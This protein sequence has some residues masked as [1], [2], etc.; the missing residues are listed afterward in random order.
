MGGWVDFDMFEKS[1]IKY[2]EKIDSNNYQISYE[3]GDEY[4]GGINNER[5]SHKHGSGSIKSKN[6]E[7]TGLWKKDMMHGKG[8]LVTTKFTFEGEFKNNQMLFG[9]C[10]YTNGKIYEGEFFEGKRHGRGSLTDDNKHYEGMW[11]NGLKEGD[12]KE[13]IKHFDDPHEGI[14]V[15]IYDGKWSKGKFI[16]GTEYEKVGESLDY[17][18]EGEFSGDKPHGEAKIEFYAFSDFKG[19]SFEGQW[20]HGKYCNGTYKGT[21]TSGNNKKIKKFSYSGSFKDNIPDKH[22]KFL[23]DDGSNYIGAHKKGSYHGLGKLENDEEIYEGEFKNNKKHG[24][25]SLLDKKSGDIIRGEW[26]NDKLEK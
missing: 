10:K 21:Y 20:K 15:T 11:E 9:L 18:C 2:Q 3:N 6:V 5:K 26:K 1:K 8:I 14:R 24:M 17:K 19:D 23:Y 13:K 25:G 16:K 12:G 22:G 7:Y 4:I